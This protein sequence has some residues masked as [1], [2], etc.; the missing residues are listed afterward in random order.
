MVRSRVSEDRQ[1]AR[2]GG[3]TGSAAHDAANGEQLS[4]IL[5]G[6]EQVCARARSAVGRC[7]PTHQVRRRGSDRD[8]PRRRTGT[9]ASVHVHVRQVDERVVSRD[10][11]SDCSRGREPVRRRT[12][13]TSTAP[14]RKICTNGLG[15]ATTVLAC[16]VWTSRTEGIYTAGMT[17]IAGG[18]FDDWE[19]GP[20][21]V[22]A[23]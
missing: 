10:R 9:A 8:L 19:G 13:C 11:G 14:C 20:S 18:V 17:W 3:P 23:S 1:R 4:A 22:R 7:S 12:S 21:A 5:D 15:P 16:A 6:M 2:G